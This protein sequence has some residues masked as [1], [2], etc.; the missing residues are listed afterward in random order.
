MV[1]LDIEFY[2]GYYC[3][4]FWLALFFDTKSVILFI[5]V[6][7]YV[8]CL[9]FLC[10][11]LRFVLINNLITMALMRSSAFVELGFKFRNSLSGGHALK[12]S[13]VLP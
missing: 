8:V 6:P 3:T 1:L 7:W 5:F 9:L 12:Q 11:F 4:V 10:L 2:V 13:S